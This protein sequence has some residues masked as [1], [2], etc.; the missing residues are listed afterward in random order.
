MKKLNNNKTANIVAGNCFFTG[1]LLTTVVASGLSTL[2]LGWLAG[3][4]I[5][6]DVAECWNS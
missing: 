4:A 2:G 6:D 1:V 3:Y 5:A